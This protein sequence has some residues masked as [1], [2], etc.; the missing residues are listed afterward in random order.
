MPNEE[1]PGDLTLG[2][3]YSAGHYVYMLRCQGGRIY[4]GY[5]VDVLSRYAKHLSGKG[6]QFTRAFP[7]ERI[8]RIFT[9]VS[10]SEA[11]RLEACIKTLPKKNKELLASAAPYEATPHKSS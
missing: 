9:C 10:K 5:A 6:A 3:P 4:T 7:P 1:S 11:L 2:T 8:L